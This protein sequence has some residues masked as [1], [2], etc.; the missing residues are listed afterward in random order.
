MKWDSSGLKITGDMLAFVDDLQ[1]SGQSTE[2]AWS[3][4]RQAWLRLQYFGIQ[5][6]PRKS[7]PPTQ[8]PRAWV[9]SV[10]DT[11]QDRVIQTVT[12]KKWDRGAKAQIQEI[13]A[14]YKDNLGAT[15]DI[16]YKRME[17]VRGFL[18]HLA[19]TS[20]LIAIYLKGFHLTLAS[21]HPNRDKQGRIE[22]VQAGVDGFLV[23]RPGERNNISCQVWGNI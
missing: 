11:T 15:P 23:G 3:I 7:R 18:G 5:D 22:A 20:D 6:A 17:E 1:A 10:L 14:H 21:I 2:E 9:G 16:N 12:Q 19:M 13:L 4:A 8:L